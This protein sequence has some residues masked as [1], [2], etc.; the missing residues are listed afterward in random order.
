MHA[1]LRLLVAPTLCLVLALPLH[2][3][4]PVIGKLH[5]DLRLPTIDGKRTIRLSDL[6]GKKVM[7]IQF[8]SW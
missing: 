1:L 3:E 5:P 4:E 8:A 2:A 7:L 6:R